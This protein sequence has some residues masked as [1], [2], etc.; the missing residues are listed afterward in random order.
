MVSSQHDLDEL[1]ERTAG[2][3]LGPEA[4][5]ERIAATLTPPERAALFKACLRAY[6]REVLAGT[7]ERVPAGAAAPSKGEADHPWRQYPNASRVPD[8]GRQELDFAVVD[9]KVVGVVTFR[10]D[11]CRQSFPDV[12]GMLEHRAKPGRCYSEAAEALVGG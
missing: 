12:D 6:C 8:L 1:I 3:G 10:C 11:G 5:A 9:E 2:G 7:K 4:V